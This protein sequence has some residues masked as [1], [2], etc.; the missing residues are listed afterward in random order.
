MS[1]KVLLTGASG[2]IALHVLDQL[3]TAGYEVVGTVRSEEKA[4]PIKK[5]L[6]KE[7]PSGKYQ[8]EVVVDIAAPNAFDAVFQK[9]TDLKYVL[10][11]ASP[12][13]FG[14]TKSN[15][16]NYLIPATHGTKSV[17]ESI[18]KYGKNVEH[19]VVTSSFAAIV[20]RHR[21]GD[22]TFINDETTWN[23]VIWEDAR[24]DAATSYVASK[25]YAE[26]LAWDFVKDNNSTFNLTTVN[27]P[28]VFGP[29]KFTFGLARA[30]LNTSAD[31]VNKALKTTPE[32]E[33]PF[34][35]PAGVACDVRDVAKLH[36]LPLG[37]KEFNGQRLFPVSDT[38]YGIEEYEKGKFNFEKILRILNEKFPELKGKISPGGIK[39]NEAEL[40]KLTYYRNKLTT[41][42]TKLTFYKL[43]DTI[44]DAAKQILDYEAS[45]K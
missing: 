5:E 1:A 37:K 10:H 36:V 18:Q 33:G 42:S 23:P 11:T 45:Q 44:Y 32:Y 22:P 8:F 17:L 14:L 21:S 2:F 12:F 35:Q 13:S 38:G 7:H 31:F 25:K 24:E 34:N 43:E 39:D 6:A 15:E 26:K 40:A 30:S 19:V 16:E 27:P 20:H 4:E 41:D 28:Y 29:Q 3:L 9:H